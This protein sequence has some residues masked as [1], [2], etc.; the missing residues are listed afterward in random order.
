MSESIRI[1]LRVRKYLCAHYGDYKNDEFQQ[2]EYHIVARYSCK[3]MV[4]ISESHKSLGGNTCRKMIVLRSAFGHVPVS[5]RAAVLRKM[6][7]A[8]EFAD[9]DELP[10]LLDI[11]EETIEDMIEAEGFEWSGAVVELRQDLPVAEAV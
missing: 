9:A 3:Q 2:W 5:E 11:R 1:P 7:R 4:E 6:F 10:P 8:T